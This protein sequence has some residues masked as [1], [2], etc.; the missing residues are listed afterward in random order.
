[1][2]G[3]VRCEHRESS[4]ADI[5]FTERIICASPC[6][7]FHQMWKNQNVWRESLQKKLKMQGNAFFTAKV[8]GW[9]NDPD[10]YFNGFGLEFPLQNCSSKAPTAACQFMEQ[11]SKHSPGQI[12]RKKPGMKQKVYNKQHEHMKDEAFLFSERKWK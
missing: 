1:M 3:D 11:F 8:T 7:Q 2:D 10:C 9:L 5:V 6:N 12:D 4:S